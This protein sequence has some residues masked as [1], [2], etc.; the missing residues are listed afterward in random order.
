M[1][2]SPVTVLPKPITVLFAPFAVLVAPRTVL[3][4][5]DATVLLP[6]AMAKF[7]LVKAG[8]APLKSPPPIAMLKSP[9]LNGPDRGPNIL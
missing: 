7:D 9:P 5:P 2:F 1:L 6:I 3:P 4:M 8:S